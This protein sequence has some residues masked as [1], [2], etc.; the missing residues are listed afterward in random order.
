VTQRNHEKAAFRMSRYNRWSVRA[1]VQQALAI[2]KRDITVVQLVVMAGQAAL[3][4]NRRN[5]RVEEARIA[6]GSECRGR[7][8][9]QHR[10]NFAHYCFMP[11]P[12]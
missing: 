2:L 5:A 11:M 10:G 4:E 6:I 7:S 8:Q 3:F 12:N 1:A 9:Q